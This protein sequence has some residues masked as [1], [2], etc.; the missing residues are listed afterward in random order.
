MRVNLLGKV[1]NLVEDELYD[2]IRSPHFKSFRRRNKNPDHIAECKGCEILSMC[3]GGCA[4][5]YTTCIKKVSV[6]SSRKTCIV[7][8]KSIQELI[9]TRKYEVT[10]G[11]LERVRQV[12]QGI[13]LS[14]NLI[15]T[16]SSLR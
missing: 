11:D 12:Q 8:S 6:L 4:A 7:R 1:G 15:P 16:I 3:G 9:G 2:I 10:H 5:R 14:R 13:M